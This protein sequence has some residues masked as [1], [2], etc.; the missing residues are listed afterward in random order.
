VGEPLEVSLN[1]TVSVPSTW[2]K[3]KSAFA[4][5]GGVVGVG[6]AGGGDVGGGDVGGAVG[7]SV[8]E[9]S[10]EGDGSGEGEGSG[11]GD[12][13]GARSQV[14]VGGKGAPQVLP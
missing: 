12:G 1:S 13:E 5:G 10:G 9:G 14:S 8:G 4:F 11:E 6:V 7:S 2:L 3:V